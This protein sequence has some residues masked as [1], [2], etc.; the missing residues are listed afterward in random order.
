MRDGAEAREEAQR[1]AM[2][3]SEEASQ[4]RWRRERG[5]LEREL[6]V[7]KASMSALQAEAEQ[8]ANDAEEQRLRLAKAAAELRVVRGEA[9]E[10]EGEMAG[11]LSS[12]ASSQVEV[13]SLREEV[14]NLQGMLGA[15]EEA[16]KIRL[17]E[18][19]KERLKL[20]E[21]M[22]AAHEENLCTM[23]RLREAQDLLS[24]K[25]SELASG[26]S[27]IKGLETEVRLLRREMECEV[28]KLKRALA[29]RES[30]VQEAEN[31]VCAMEVVVS[32]AEEI[33]DRCEAQLRKFGVEREEM[34]AGYASTRKELDDLFVLQREIQEELNGAREEL[35]GAKE[36]NAREKAESV[37]REEGLRE[38]LRCAREA[39]AEARRNERDLNCRL[40]GAQVEEDGKL[41][42]MEG[43]VLEVK[44]ALEVS[45][46]TIDSMS[47]RIQEDDKVIEELRVSGMALKKEKA[48]LMTAL[49][50]I[51]SEMEEV[52]DERDEVSRK[53][54]RVIE[55]WECV[56]TSIK[57]LES[58]RDALTHSNSAL[59]LQ[60]SN[61]EA[62]ME[63]LQRE[64]ENAQG[65]LERM[66]IERD[67]L[68]KDRLGLREG[69]EVADKEKQGLA[70]QK[71]ELGE[72]IDRMAGEKRDLE[73]GMKRAC[74][75]KAAM[76][77][78]LAEIKAELDKAVDERE[79][80]R[81]ARD[82]M[83]GSIDEIRMG[84]SAVQSE[85]GSLAQ[86]V[87]R[88]EGEAES[89]LMEREQLVRQ[90]DEMIQ[91][92][93][94]SKRRWDEQREEL[95]MREREERWLRQKLSNATADL[96][97]AQSKSLRLTMELQVSGEQLQSLASDL[98]AAR[99]ETA[100]ARTQA[101]GR[102]RACVELEKCVADLTARCDEF[103]DELERSKANEEACKRTLEQERRLARE[104]RHKTCKREQQLG[105][106][107]SQA[108]TT[109]S[110]LRSEN[111]VFKV[112][113]ASH[114]QKPRALFSE[115]KLS[116]HW[117]PMSDTS[118]R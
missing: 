9:E 58:E 114:R 101:A 98:E 46:E 45:R 55:E 44:E 53:L 36:E 47:W 76:E 92:V 61:L 113:E 95:L 51:R 21:A 102:D 86:D 63:G 81:A 118:R 83:E 30:A 14:A 1:E 49:G 57:G 72:R 110:A 33:A 71:E 94:D 52:R 37:E 20:D 17:G 77:E 38:E 39:L 54:S 85:R 22:H 99:E 69:M 112:R 103:K 15:S 4:E 80:M 13:E 74:N 93:D 40:E 89:L 111:M 100:V 29:A 25:D 12:L 59:S 5:E 35:N 90:L 107:I 108:Q 106:E 117:H 48:G 104:V 8:A 18:L 109:I 84:L 60:I 50:A 11:L 82:H 68:V 34:R 75:E 116:M 24:A 87:S 32:C 66:E 73:E 115:I 16:S 19:E 96:D 10:R 78:A 27:R 3:K 28:G 7:L 6:E 97:A 31:G 2:K 41:K 65:A 62:G 42:R 23:G 67:A 26:E 70:K 79:R 88:L 64:K 43:E 105:Q 91:E 56:S